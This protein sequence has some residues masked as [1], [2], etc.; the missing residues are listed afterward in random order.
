[1]RY[2]EALHLT[3]QIPGERCGDCHKDA[4]ATAVAA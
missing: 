3:Q 1:L 4:R 2:A